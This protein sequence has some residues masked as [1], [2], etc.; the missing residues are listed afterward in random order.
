MLRP[1]SIIL[2]KLIPHSGGIPG[3]TNLI[4]LDG[5]LTRSGQL[6]KGQLE[7]I[8][9]KY[10]VRSFV[11]LRPDK[12]EKVW[13]NDEVG[14]CKEKGIP[15]IHLGIDGTRLPTAMEVLAM[16]RV[17]NNYPKPMH[18]QC[19]MGSDRTGLFSGIYEMV[20]NKKT[21]AEAKKQASL[22]CGNVVPYQRRFFD[23]L[24]KANLNGNLE[25]WVQL[26]YL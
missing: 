3:Y 25:R 9:G 14:V 20:V 24:K 4:Q 18:V 12:P 11:S 15:Y 1:L 13:Y 23:L 6:T 2:R 17:A 26:E 8:I 7:K 21:A 22:Y 16:I 19:A 5:G 10:G